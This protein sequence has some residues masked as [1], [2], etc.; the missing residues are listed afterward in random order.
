MKISNI[1]G[2]LL[3]FLITIGSYD[4]TIGNAAEAK[5]KPQ[6]SCP[7]MGGEISQHDMYVDVKGKRIYICCAACE[8]AI[9]TEPD[10]YIKIIKGR[11][12]TVENS[13]SK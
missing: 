7:L 6:S 10:R 9:R 8:A 3:I 12:E 5:E 2:P 11:G 13:P 4:I 1:V